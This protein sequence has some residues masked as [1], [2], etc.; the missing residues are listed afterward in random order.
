MQMLGFGFAVDM[1]IFFLLTLSF[2]AI[3]LVLMD[4]WFEKKKYKNMEKRVVAKTI[5]PKRTK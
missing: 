4:E 1:L 3:V 2:I 5:K